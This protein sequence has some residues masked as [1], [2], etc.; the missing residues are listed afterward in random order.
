M[1]FALQ[2]KHAET[3]FFSNI[4]DDLKKLKVQWQKE[5]RTDWIKKAD[6]LIAG[7]DND[8]N[9]PKLISLKQYLGRK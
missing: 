4:L 2:G 5:K 6:E 9:P 7:I 1:A 8:K 3:M